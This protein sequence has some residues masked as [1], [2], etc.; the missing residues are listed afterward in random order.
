[1]TSYKDAFQQKRQNERST[2]NPPT[3][4]KLAPPFAAAR[5]HDDFAD[6][7]GKQDLKLGKEAKFFCVGSCFAREIED[8][9]EN[10][11]FDALTKSRFITLMEDNPDLFRRKEGAAGRPYAFLNRYNTGSMADLMAVVAEQQA[12]GTELLYPASDPELFHD[13]HY[14]RLLAEQSLEDCQ[15]R[16]ALITD[17]YRTAAREADV[18]VFTLGLCESFQDRLNKRYLNVTP[19]PRTAAK[20]ELDFRFQSFEDNLKHGQT[21]IDAVRQLNP[22]AHIIFTVSPVPLDV[23]F[24]DQDIV[25]ANSLAKSTLVLTAQTLV[26]QHEGCLYF[27]SYEMVMNSAQ[28]KA[29]H[30]DR[31]H[32][33]LPMVRHIMQSF[34]AQYIS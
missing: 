26:Q 23:T 30:W 32:V 19:D 31:K 9:I 2:W 13:Y 24:L 4:D 21:V 6:L 11:G 28:D 10:I 8:A 15:T 16:R 7:R 3:Q 12:E 27:P 34:I 20:L 33:S 5:I 18:F 29:W 22:N 25:V 17:T 1:M 14:T